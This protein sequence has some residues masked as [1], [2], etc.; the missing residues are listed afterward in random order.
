MSQAAAPFSISRIFKARYKTIHSSID[1]RI[2]G[3]F[4][5]LDAYLMTI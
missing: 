2:G 5:K 1:F 3:T 4:A